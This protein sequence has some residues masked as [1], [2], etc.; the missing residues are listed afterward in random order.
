[1]RRRR[2]ST[3]PLVAVLVVGGPLTA[4][5]G[6]PHAAAAPV[7]SSW[8]ADPLPPTRWFTDPPR[9]AFFA[10]PRPSRWFTDPLPCH[11]EARA[12]HPGVDRAAYDALIREIAGRHRVEYALVKAMIHAESDFDRLAVS[13]KGACGLMQLM[14]ATASSE[15]VR[16]VFLARENIEGGCRYLRQLLD[17]YAGNL[18]LALAA[19]NAGPER[20]DAAHGIPPIAETHEYLTRVLEYR[21]GYLRR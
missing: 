5:A 10:G 13:P 14:P 7:R 19:Y 11:E 20:V 2:P 9:S 18:P 17:R 21:L 16:D 12:G 1:V 3:L 4:R 8:F 6:A 15:G